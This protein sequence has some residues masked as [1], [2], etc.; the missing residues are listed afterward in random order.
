M[1]FC[2]KCGSDD[3]H[4][5]LE[6]ES[7]VRYACQACDAIHYQNPLLV[8][9]C[10]PVYQQQVLLC[11]RGIEPRKGYWNLPAGFM[12]LNESVTAGALRELTEETGLS[13]QIIRLHSVYTARQKNQVM[14]HFL[15]RLENI[16]F[17]LNEESVAI[18][19][20]E[21]NDIPWGKLAFKSNV[22]A[23]KSYLKTL[24]S[25]TNEVFISESDDKNG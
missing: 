19:L 23:L 12:E 21:L 15:T 18:Q 14:L 13:G 22:F 4:L 16:D 8:V 25:P 17:S 1:N 6:Q 10:V 7:F 24:E 9:G 11:K 20:F 5:R 2:S 3:V